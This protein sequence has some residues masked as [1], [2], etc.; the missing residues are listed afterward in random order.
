MDFRLFA[1]YANLFKYKDLN[2]LESAIN[3]ELRKVHI[4]LCA[5]K[6]LVNIEKS[7]FV[8]FHPVQKQIP[9]KI[10]LFIN[11]QSLTEETSTRYLGVYIG[12]SIS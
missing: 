1:D 8:I 7:N 6:L 3:T 2:I 9:K 5:N 12:S 10:M 4:W 11:D